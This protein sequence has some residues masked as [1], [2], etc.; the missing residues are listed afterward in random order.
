MTIVDTA[1]PLDARPRPPLGVR[2]LMERTFQL[3][4]AAF[5]P[6]VGTCLVYFVLVQIGTIF[7]TP[8]LLG[9]GIQPMPVDDAIS[10]GATPIQIVI[11]AAGF[12]VAFLVFSVFYGA[13]LDIALK[14]DA[15]EPANFGSAVGKGFRFTVPMFLAF[16]VL[17]ILIALGLMAFVVPGIWLIGVYGLVPVVMIAENRARGV[18]GRTR[19]LT[20]DYRW[21]LI[22]FFALLYVALFVISFLVG[23]IAALI[24]PNLTN[25]TQIIIRS[26]LID[27]P[28]GAI[29]TALLIAGF[30]VAYR[31][32]IEIKEG[33]GTDALRTVFE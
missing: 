8:Q 10:T 18:L 11:G 14:R 22:G 7:V 21:P 5:L 9:L 3:L 17:A 28:V 33:D 16:I 15:G 2:V 1:A 13:M 25:M 6:L 20:K 19:K 4:K 31:R 27:A 23:V 26:L 32:M 12:L 29:T 30:A 24:T